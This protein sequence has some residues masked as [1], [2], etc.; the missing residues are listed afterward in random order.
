MF[1]SYVKLPEST[2][3][4]DAQKSG[5]IC[6]RPHCFPEPWDHGGKKG[7]HPKMALLQ[8]TGSFL[9]AGDAER[10]DQWFCFRLVNFCSSLPRY[11]LV[12]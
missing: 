10:E 4:F 12:I 1:N 6:S 2:H 5:Q 3:C 9:L 8:V 11:Y 7:N